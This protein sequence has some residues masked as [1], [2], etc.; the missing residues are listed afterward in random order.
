MRLPG[1]SGWRRLP[2][3]SSR[4]FR[5]P[6]PHSVIL[7]GANLEEKITC[8]KIDYAPLTG[9]ATAR[10]CSPCLVPD[11]HSWVSRELE[12]GLMRKAKS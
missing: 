1:R 6:H 2:R 10:T 12:G 8:R 7:G 11:L 4:R 9:F 3:P 5:T